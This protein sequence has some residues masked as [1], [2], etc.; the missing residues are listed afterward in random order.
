[1]NVLLV[2]ALWLGAPLSAVAAVGLGA[3]KFG[4]RLDARRDAR[5]AARPVY[6]GT[7]RADAAYATSY[8]WIELHRGPDPAERGRV[9]ADILHFQTAEADTWDAEGDH[10]WCRFNSF[11]RRID[12]LMIAIASMSDLG[13]GPEDLDQVV[14]EYVNALPQGTGIPGRPFVELLADVARPYV[15]K[16]AH[17]SQRHARADLVD[18]LHDALASRIPALP[19]GALRGLAGALRSEGPI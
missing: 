11:H 6:L 16:L 2:P 5:L 17:V 8:W 15:E 7:A 14:R 3:V 10:E 9:M 13:I 12:I 18:A 4:P 19:G 1:M